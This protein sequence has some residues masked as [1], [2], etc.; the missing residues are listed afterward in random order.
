[1]RVRAEAGN[2]RKSS[3]AKP[4]G[5]HPTQVHSKRTGLPTRGCKPCTSRGWRF[6]RMG[7]SPRPRTLTTRFS[8]AS[9]GISARYIQADPVKVGAWNDRLGPRT[10]PPIGLAWRGNPGHAADNRRSIPLA[11]LRGALAPNITWFSLH[12]D[13]RD[14]DA[15][16]L[17]ASTDIRHFGA[18]MDFEQTAALI[19]RM[20]LVISVDTSIAHLAGAMGKP[21]WI[22]LPFTPA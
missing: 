13:A 16:L 17:A 6:I 19:D 2:V 14:A 7:G 3:T 21:T 20:D 4:S 1:M 8:G 11:V 15:P 5:G 18:E 22:L 10:Q 12:R 9:P